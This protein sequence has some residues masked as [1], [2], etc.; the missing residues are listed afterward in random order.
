MAQ[1]HD[2]DPLGV[3][4]D[5][6]GQTDPDDA[7]LLEALAASTI[8]VLLAKPPGEGANRPERNLIEWHVARFATPY[9]ST[10]SLRIKATSLA[11]GT[12]PSRAKQVVDSSG[13]KC[14]FATPKGPAT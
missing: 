5:E 2:D 14:H 8:L 7:G 1:A 13:A 6:L 4:L 12:R 9:R 11:Y 10:T 3:R